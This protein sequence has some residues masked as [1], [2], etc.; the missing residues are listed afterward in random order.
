M[1]KEYH[2]GDFFDD[3]A[4]FWKHVIDRHDSDR[5]ERPFVGD[6]SQDGDM[7][8]DWDIDPDDFG[9]LSDILIING[10]QEE[11]ESSEYAT[12]QYT[13]A[14]FEDAVNYCREAPPG[15]LK[16]MVLPDGQIEIYRYP[17]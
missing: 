5:Q 10:S 4:A 3:A 1:A 14:Q 12:G 11:L 2:E 9:D 13:I 15:I 8:V 6:D 17:S 16:L 7:P